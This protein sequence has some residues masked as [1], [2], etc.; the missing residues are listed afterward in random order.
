M[1]ADYPRVEPAVDNP[2]TC[3]AHSVTS[4]V[5]ILFFDYLLNTV[6]LP[7]ALFEPQSLEMDRHG[8]PTSIAVGGRVLK[9]EHDVLLGI[10]SNQ[11]SIRKV[12]NGCEIDQDRLIPGFVS[13]AA[14]G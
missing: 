6:F 3:T 11:P 7:G 4:A 2:N 13:A 10:E 9:I 1:I 12:I 14:K 8:I 5:V